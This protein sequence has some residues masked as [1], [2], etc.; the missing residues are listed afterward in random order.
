MALD[1]THPAAIQRKR[2]KNEYNKRHKAEMLKLLFDPN[3]YSEQ[4]KGQH[5]CQSCP[6]YNECLENLWSWQAS[7]QGITYAPLRCFAEHP[8]Y[9]VSEWRLRNPD[10]AN[11]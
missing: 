5:G 2:R 11:A 6:Y 4:A 9:D 10:L 1:P 8:Q 7:P 3:Y